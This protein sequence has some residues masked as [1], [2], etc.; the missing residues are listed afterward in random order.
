MRGRML[1]LNTKTPMFY[2]TMLVAVIIFAKTYTYSVN[3]YTHKKYH[4]HFLRSNILK[5]GRYLHHFG[6]GFFDI[7]LIRICNNLHL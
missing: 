1:N 2:D 6:F 4:N 3:N 7:C 5:Q